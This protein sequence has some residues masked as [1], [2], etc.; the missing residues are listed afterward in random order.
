M[1]F[2]ENHKMSVKK[3]DQNYRYSPNLLEKKMKARK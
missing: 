3:H 1:N 2:Q